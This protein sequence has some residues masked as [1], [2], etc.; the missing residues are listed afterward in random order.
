[1][2]F[3]RLQD[4]R[5]LIVDK[6]IKDM[7]DNKLHWSQTWVDTF[8]PNNPITGTKY[9]GINRITL[10]MIAA[11]RE[12]KD[13]RWVTAKE[14]FASG[15][16]IKKGAKSAAVEKWK[17]YKTKDD[18]DT[19]SVIDSKDTKVIPVCVGYFS[20][21]NA[22]EIE[23]IPPLE[24][25]E[26]EDSNI[27]DVADR[28]IETSRCPIYEHDSDVAYWSSSFDIISIP[29]RSLFTS[30]EAFSR[31]LLHEMGHSTGH[32][33]CLARDMS[34]GR[35]SKEYAFEELIAEMSAVF[36]SVDLGLDLKC[37]LDDKFYENHVAYLQC[38]LSRLE[39]NPDEL[40][41]AAAAAEKATEVIL[42]NYAG[43]EQITKVA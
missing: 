8:A 23:G 42:D 1:M 31:T 2:K 15:W 40:F 13:P 20:V 7:K 4:Q 5:K 11:I 34:G 43:K 26:N 41:V 35:F 18:E 22:N 3:E 28:L 10:G 16:K 29:S 17:L 19:E 38:W 32:R 9:R 6:V 27:N 14:A 33:S 24:V 39:N 36:S 25:L 21:F 37:D 30:I 12:Y